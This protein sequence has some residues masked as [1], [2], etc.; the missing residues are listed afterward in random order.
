MNASLPFKHESPEA[1]LYRGSRDS[2]LSLHELLPSTLADLIG[3]VQ[4]SLRTLP[5][6]RL[7]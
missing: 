6:K 4:G 1:I 5:T 2:A 3:F 7:D